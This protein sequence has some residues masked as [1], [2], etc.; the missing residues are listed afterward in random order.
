VIVNSKCGLEANIQKGIL[1]FEL[2]DVD[3][4]SVHK[5]IINERLDRQK[6]ESLKQVLT[7]QFDPKLSVITVAPSVKTASE[8]DQNKQDTTFKALEGRHFLT[9]MKELYAEGKSFNGLEKGQIM[10]VVINCPGVVAAN[11]VNMRQ[12]YLSEKHSKKINIQDFIKLYKRIDDVIHERS[13]AI[14]LVKN[15]MLMFDF[16]KDDCTAVSRICKWSEGSLLKIIE[17]FEFYENF[18]SLDSVNAEG[19]TVKGM[20]LLMKAGKKLSVKKLPFHRIAKIPEENLTEMANKVISREISLL[21][22]ATWSFKNL[23]L[24]NVKQQCVEIS[25]EILDANDEVEDFEDLVKMLPDDF[26]DAKLVEFSDSVKGDTFKT[27]SRLRLENHILESFGE[28]LNNNLKEGGMIQ[29]VETDNLHSSFFDDAN[30]V[31]LNS[32]LLEPDCIDYFV[33]KV[34]SKMALLIICKTQVE[35]HNAIAIIQSHESEGDVVKLYSVVVKDSKVKVSESSEISGC[36]ILFLIIM[37]DF[38]IK[39]PPL[40]MYHEGL[41][42]CLDKIV[43]QITPMGG[44]VYSVNY[45]GSPVSFLTPRSSFSY[46]YFGSGQELRRVKNLTGSQKFGDMV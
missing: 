18:Q 5:G 42:Q 23:Q 21:D 24:E 6:I 25:K 7:S 16:H 36:G 17:L 44:K 41:S 9:A 33:K 40:L 45:M 35:F 19:V 20:A 3:K 46:T 22:M 8:Y 32:K 43:Q 13:R 30:T 10:A 37:G 34:R 28:K 2:I 1:A 29:F 12:T 39:N 27:G 11:Y 26:S 14:E 38:A 4:I 15:S 31:I